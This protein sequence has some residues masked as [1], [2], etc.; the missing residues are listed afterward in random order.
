MRLSN[1]LGRNG[2]LNPFG[3]KLEKVTRMFTDDKDIIRP[4]LE[5]GSLLKEKLKAYPDIYHGL[6]PEDVWVEEEFA[7][8]FRARELLDYGSSDSDEPSDSAKRKRVEEPGEKTL[9]GREDE[10]VFPFEEDGDSL[11][12]SRETTKRRRI[13]SPET[14]VIGST[15]EEDNATVPQEV[16]VVSSG[17]EGDNTPP[18]SLSPR[19]IVQADAPLAHNPGYMRN[20]TPPGMTPQHSPH[21]DLAARTDLLE[22][23]NEEWVSPPD[24]NDLRPLSPAPAE[25]PQPESSR[26]HEPGQKGPPE[27]SLAPPPQ[28]GSAA[29]ARKSLPLPFP[30]S[31]FPPSAFP[32]PRTRRLPRFSPDIQ[33]DYSVPIPAVEEIDPDE[34]DRAVTRL[35]RFGWEWTAATERDGFRRPPLGGLLEHALN[36]LREED[37]DRRKTWQAEFKDT[38]EWLDY[39]G[40]GGLESLEETNGKCNLQVYN[41]FLDAKRKVKAIKAFEREKYG[42]VKPGDGIKA[43]EDVPL[44]KRGKRPVVKDARGVRLCLSEEVKDEGKRSVLAVKPERVHTQFPP[45]DADGAEFLSHLNTSER[46]FWAAAPDTESSRDYLFRLETA[47]YEACSAPGGPLQGYKTEDGYGS[48]V[49]PP[50]DA[51]PTAPGVLTGL[52]GRLHASAVERGARRAALQGA[53]RCFANTEQILAGTEWSRVVPGVEEGVLEAVRRDLDRNH[54]FGSGTVDWRTAPVARDGT[55]TMGYTVAWRYHRTLMGELAEHTRKEVDRINCETRG[56]VTL[57]RNLGNGGPFVWRGVDPDVQEMQDLLKEC[58][59]V[60]KG[61]VRMPRMCAEPVLDG[62]KRWARGAAHGEFGMSGVRGLPEN[63]RLGRDDLETTGQLVRN[64]GREEL[65]WLRFLMGRYLNKSMLETEGGYKPKL[66]SIFTARL[67][68]MMDDRSDRALLLDAERWATIEEL[69]EIMNR[70]CD[71]SG[72]RYQFSP[73]EARHF[74]ERAQEQGLCRYV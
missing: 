24:K 17:S 22:L 9:E 18:S 44:P 2:I 29:T 58:E 32:L 59:G 35:D 40:T 25:S 65:G 15:D 26:S 38:E 14:I 41:M 66:Y 3:D 67:E 33:P 50:R 63:M 47:A 52:G 4:W 46:A 39:L 71:Q 16:V 73:F 30:P 5:N 72:R 45:S 37:G 53:L 13:Q 61:I 60:F 20:P 68:K 56:W 6:W 64:V 62:V 55:E 1:Y 10:S 36:Y 49:L 19:S 21:P 69:L 23:P 7:A 31:A 74:L 34:Q 42:V 51:L 12:S 11:G 8:S 48:L 70:G 57:P 43:V 54:Q 27:P 28:V